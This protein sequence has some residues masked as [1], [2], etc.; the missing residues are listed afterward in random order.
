MVAEKETVE[1]FIENPPP[2]WL[3]AEKSNSGY[4]INIWIRSINKV[5]D[6]QAMDKPPPCEIV[7]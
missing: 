7:P 5:P 3:S 2:L 4:S 6:Q 1:P